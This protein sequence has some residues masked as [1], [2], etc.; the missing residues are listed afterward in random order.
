MDDR[1]RSVVSGPWSLIRSELFW[2]LALTLLGALLRLWM[3]GSKG[4][5]YDEAS[6]AL[7]ARAAPMQII[8]FHWNAA[9]EHPPFWILLM[10]FW[11]T[12]FGQGEA[13]LRLPSALAGALVAPMMWQIARTAW[14]NDRMTRLLAAGLVAT[15]PVLVLYAQEARMYSLV[16]VLALV[17]VYLGMRIPANPRA[18]HVTAFVLTNWIMLGLHYYSA[19]LVAIESAFL[20]VYAIRLRR[21]VGVVAL[22]AGLSII[23]LLLWAWLAPGF[24]TTVDVV[25]MTTGGERR[26]P[27]SFLDGFWRDAVFGAVR[28]QPPRAALGYLL[29]PFLFTGVVQGFRKS[30]AQGR[31]GSSPDAVRWEI[32]FTAIFVV[33][34]IVGLALT[35]GMATRYLLWV[36]PAA[37][38]LIA[39]GISTLWR[40]WRPLGVV[41]LLVA[42]FVAVLGLGYYFTSYQKSE[43]RE[44]AA[45]LTSQAAAEDGIILEAPRQHLLTKYYLPTA[46]RVYPM[47]AVNLPD[48]WPLTAPPLVPEEADHQLQTLLEEHGR[49]WVVLTGEDE[50]DP[51]EFVERY[52]TAIAYPVGCREWLD[53]R[54]CPFISPGRAPDG[55]AVPLDVAFD[56]GLELRGAQVAAAKGSSGGNL[57]YAALQW[58]A[59][60]TPAAD[61]KV[62]LRLLGRDGMVLSQSDSYPIGPLLPPA[63]WSAGDDKPGYTVLEIPRTIAPGTYDL[64]IGLYDPTSLRLMPFTGGPERLLDLVKLAAIK[65]DGAGELSVMP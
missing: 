16:A 36:V 8:Q 56:G 63:T 21:S 3:L 35:G 5:W 60:E 64:A 10:R 39:L 50:V 34:L 19:L 38:L 28:W 43:Y 51:G 1:R 41:G 23:P 20:L 45:Y 47:P 33:P 46:S 29:L 54:L 59:R 61:Y 57:L 58:H 2:V 52:L 32:L 48:Y 49:L 37:Y 44:M 17:S 14:P 15:S 25:F 7:M 12:V 4:L 13:A 11:S 9:F 53:V 6:T 40:L 30:E 24:R 65:V 18:L 26:P 31:A 27:V 42:G 22:A 62:T 55:M